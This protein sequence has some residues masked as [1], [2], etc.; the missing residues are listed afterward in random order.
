MSSVPGPLSSIASK[1]RSVSA[2]AERRSSGDALVPRGGRVGLVEPQDVHELL[3]SRSY[4]AG[5]SSSG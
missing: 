5:S 1:R 2:V 4:A 3:Q